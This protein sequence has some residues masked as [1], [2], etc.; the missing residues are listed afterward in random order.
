MTVTAVGKQLSER[1]PSK[2]QVNR[3]ADAI[4]SMLTSYLAQLEPRARRSS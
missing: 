1:R 3:M 4:S 2:V